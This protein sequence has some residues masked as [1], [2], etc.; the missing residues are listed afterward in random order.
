MSSDIVD[1]QPRDL[2][3]VTLRNLLDETLRPFLSMENVENININKPREVWVEQAGGERNCHIVPTLTR[4]KL[5]RLALEVAT[6]EGMD[7]DDPD[8][9]LSTKLKDGSRIEVFKSSCVMSGIAIAIRMRKTG[10][11]DLKDFGFS[12]SDIRDLKKA[13]EDRKTILIAGGTSSGKTTVF[14]NIASFIPDHRR[15]IAIQDPV[16]IDFKQPNVL[17]LTLTELD[18]E[19]RNQQLMAITATAMRQNPDILLIGETREKYMASCFRVLC[20]TGHPGSMT[21]IHADGTQ[22]ALSRIARLCHEYSGGDL[23]Y[24]LEEINKIIDLVI[25]VKKQDDGTRVGKIEV[26]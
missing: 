12:V 9:P 8:K 20:Q 22:E 25:F 7:F 15:I 14:E 5:E 18:F 1:L 6:S 23:N 13:V 4:D 21:T 17:D 11:F 10:L 16:E 24:I 2:E 19:K 3:P 26:I